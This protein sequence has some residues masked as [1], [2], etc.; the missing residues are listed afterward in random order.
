MIDDKYV[1]TI[2]IA[3]GF[4][5][6]DVWEFIPKIVHENWQYTNAIFSIRFG[7]PFACFIQI[8]WS[9][10][11][12]IQFGLG[13]KQ[14]GRFAIHCRVQTDA[15]SDVGYHEGYPNNNTKGFSYGGH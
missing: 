1:K 12:F 7:L 14:S 6:F 3:W 13:W 2:A 11:H 10:N 9:S 5:I 8:R 15:S 4:K